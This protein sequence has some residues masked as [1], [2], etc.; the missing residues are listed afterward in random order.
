[1]SAQ[2][3]HGRIR[4]K[5]HCL[6]FRPCFQR[7]EYMLGQKA[8]LHSMPDEKPTVESGGRPSALIF[9]QLPSDRNVCWYNSLIL[10]AC[11]TKHPATATATIKTPA[12]GNR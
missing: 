1:M 4:G 2:K 10:I 8:Y 12:G 7:A 3:R 11:R 6:N 9:D 5:T